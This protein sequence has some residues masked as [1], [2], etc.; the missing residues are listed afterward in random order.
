MQSLCTGRQSGID[1]SL[2]RPL[3]SV[4]HVGRQDYATGAFEANMD[5]RATELQGILARLGP[6]FAKVSTQHTALV[7][8][9]V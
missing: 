7:C 3:N 1:K 9:H 6:S 2:T 8:S 5:R 4:V